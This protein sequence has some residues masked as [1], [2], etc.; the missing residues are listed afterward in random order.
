MLY[1]IY[2]QKEIFQKNNFKKYFKKVLTKQKNKQKTTKITN[3]NTYTV[4]SPLPRP[5]SSIFHIKKVEN[6]LTVVASVFRE[7]D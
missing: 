7:V 6:Y 5:T 3:N 1:Y 2:K 4:G